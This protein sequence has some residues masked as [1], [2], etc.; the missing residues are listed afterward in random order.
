M[1][2][3][4][5]LHTHMRVAQDLTGVVLSLCAPQKSSTHSMFHPPLLDLPD[6]FAS[7]CSTPQQTT[8]NSLLLTGIR[9]A[10]HLLGCCLAIF[11]VSS[12]HT[13][14]N[15]P[16]RRNS[17]NI[18]LPP[19]SQPPKTPM[20]YTSKRQPAVVRSPYQQVW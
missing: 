15:Y 6:P 3:T 2:R 11:E 14:V 7:F 10:L 19:Q 9:G 5:N 16:S 20:V 8:P 1:S 4:F 17:F 13:P 18:T 12:E